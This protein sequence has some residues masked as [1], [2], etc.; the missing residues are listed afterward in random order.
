MPLECR[1]RRYVIRSWGSC[2]CSVSVRPGAFG[3]TLD[4]LGAILYYEVID[5]WRY[6]CQIH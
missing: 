4:G 5:L 1:G 3:P 2:L 6:Q